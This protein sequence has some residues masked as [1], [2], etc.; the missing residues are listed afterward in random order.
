MSKSKYP[1]VTAVQPP[2]PPIEKVV[3]ELT[4]SQAKTLRQLLSFT[5]SVPET[6]ER[7]GRFSK[8]FGRSELIDFMTDL[9]AALV[10]AMEPV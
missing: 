7:E 6:L 1:K 2:A 8:E 5:T 3:I 10:V 4:A 9:H